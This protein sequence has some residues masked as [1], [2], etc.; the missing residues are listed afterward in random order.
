MTIH[1]SWLNL[2][3]S[4][5]VNRCQI[6]LL[7][8]PALAIPAIPLGC[9]TERIIGAN[10]GGTG[11][12]S[13]TGGA[14]PVGGVAGSGGDET[15]IIG[16]TLLTGGTSNTGGTSST[17]GTSTTSSTEPRAQACL[18]SG[19][20]VT[21]SLCCSGLT[22]DFPDLCA[23]G[24]CGCSPSNSKTISTCQCG[25]NRCWDGQSCVSQ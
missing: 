10:T 15:I 7:V 3:M 23:I 8:V 2:A 4:Y 24:A 25:T 9:G 21:A 18:A 22:S 6:V 17:G 14:A 11:G 1:I 12:N 16:T 13:T 20:V 5:S 19:G